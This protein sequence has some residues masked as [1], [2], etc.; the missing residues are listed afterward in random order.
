MGSR[1]IRFFLSGVLL[2]SGLSSRPALAGNAP[3]GQA[4]TAGAAFLKIGVGA[5][6]IG[7]GGAYT[8]VSDDAN[9]IY[10]NPAGLTRFNGTQLSLMHT[11]WVQDINY[12][13]IGIAY[14][15]SASSGFAFGM[16]FLW[17]DDM[18]VT[19]FSD[20]LGASGDTFT[21][22][23]LSF[24]FSYAHQIFENVSLGG[25]LKRIRSTIADISATATAFDIG[26]MIT[27]PLPGLALGTT[28]QNFGTRLKFMKDGDRL[29]LVYKA[30]AAY[31]Y[32]DV[33]M[34][35]VDIS[36]PVDNRVRVNAG[37]EVSLRN[38]LALRGG[39]NSANDL[40]NGFMGGAGVRIRYISIDYAFVPYG[41]LGNTHRISA[42]FSF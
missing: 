31:T 8:A 42:M 6:P 28:I 37:A 39:Y 19:T 3:H 5:R 34:L 38:T 40:D 33:A 30:G 11:R 13:F 2:L 32:R 15:D 18:P 16:T 10:W 21:A 41:V 26:L 24:V 9:S 7:L 35:S 29:P 14:G 23:D 20:R 17:M 12:E 4:G 36:K 25:N 22:R 27:P 1:S